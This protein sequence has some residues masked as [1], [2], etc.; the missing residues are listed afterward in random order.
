MEHITLKRDKEPEKIVVAV[1]N[2]NIR[3]EDIQYDTIKVVKVNGNPI[4][5][6]N[7]ILKI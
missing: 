3:L 4:T 1:H 7:D 5:I 6:D 2:G